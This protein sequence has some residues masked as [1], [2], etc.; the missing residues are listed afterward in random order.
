[1]TL[2]E[3]IESIHTLETYLQRFED[4]YWLRSKDLFRLVQQGKLEQ[5]PDFIE[6]LG[7]Y[8]IKLR[9]EQKIQQR[10]ASLS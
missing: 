5:S 7:I 10:R 4:K 6:W 2:N 8:E 3:L 1:M 9:R